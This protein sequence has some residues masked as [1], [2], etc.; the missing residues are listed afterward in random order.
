[1][2]RPIAAPRL[3]RGYA[4]PIAELQAMQRWA[5]RHRLGLTIELDRCR[6]GEDYEEVVTLHESGGRRR[7]WSLWRS[8]EHL[9]VEPAF[10][11]AARFARLADALGALRL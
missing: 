9:V 6:D 10:G 4:F 7:R 3:P 2:T 11:P 8:A 1:M 5:A